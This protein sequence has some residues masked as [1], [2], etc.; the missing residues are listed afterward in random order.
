LANDVHLQRNLAL[1]TLAHDQ[2]L[3]SLGTLTNNV[4]GVLLVL[5]FAREGELVLGL[6]VGDFVNTE[7]LVCGAEKAR[8]VTFDI[9][10]VVELGSQRVLH[11]NDNDLPVGLL[12]VKEGHDAKNL[13]LLDLTGFCD[14]LTDLADVERVIVP[15]GLSLRVNDVR[16]FPCLSKVRIPS[17]LGRLEVGGPPYLRESAVV[18]EVAL[19]WET[20]ADEAKLALLGVLLDRVELLLLRDLRV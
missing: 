7:P 15:L 5:A 8:E 11:I 18:P 3:P 17:S 9:F 4:H 6:A 14:Q 2:A 20:V 10:D 16:V 12:L 19:V 1:V 13:D